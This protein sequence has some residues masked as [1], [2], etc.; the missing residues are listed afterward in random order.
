MTEANSCREIARIS[1]SCGGE[2]GLQKKKPDKR[3]KKCGSNDVQISVKNE[4]REQGNSLFSPYV[5]LFATGIRQFSIECLSCGV[6]NCVTI[7][8]EAWKSKEGR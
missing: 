1:E 4:I 3:C 8:D 7:Y 6:R 2:P 5:K